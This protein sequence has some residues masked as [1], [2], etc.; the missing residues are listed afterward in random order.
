MATSPGDAQTPDRARVRLAGISS[1]AYEHPADRGALVAL[2]KLT[3]FDAVL[4]KIS[5]LFS[6][7]RLRLISLASAVKA[8]E[9]QF[10]DLHHYVRDA[11]YVL[12]LPDVPELYVVQDAQ[13]GLMTVGSDHPFVVMTSGMHDLLD[14]AERRFAIGH[15]VGHVLSGHAVYRT[16]LFGLTR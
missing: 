9:T 2:R 6:E 1:R 14:P 5:G 15:E 10:K 11:A 8:G 7:R 3:A 12:D 13:P 4:R 16:L